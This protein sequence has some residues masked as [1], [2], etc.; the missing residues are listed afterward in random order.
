MPFR[1]RTAAILLSALCSSAALGT[2][3]VETFISAIRPSADVGAVDVDL[4]LLNG[5]PA[6]TAMTLPPRL[7]AEVT[8]DG[9]VVHAWLE[10]SSGSPAT[11]RIP[12]GG[13]SRAQYRL[14]LPASSPSQKHASL[15][16][17]GWAAPPVAF[18]IPSAPR[19]AQ[20]YACSTGLASD[21]GPADAK[22]VA[23]APSDRSAGNAFLANLSAYEPI[24]AVYGPG[25]NTEARIQLSFKY[26]LLGY[27]AQ[28]DKARS[29]PNGLYFAYTQ[30]M[31]WDVGAKSS[32]FRN[33]DYQPELFYLSPPLTLSSGATVS[34]QAGLRHE[35]NGRDG[36]ASRSLNTVYV[37]P[38]AAIPLS[39][40]YRLTLAP[41]LWLYAGDLGDNPDIRRYRGNTGLFA[42]I[43]KDDGLRL[44]TSTRFNFGSCK[45]S[46]A[47]D[48]SYPLSRVLGGGPDFY[49]FGQSFVGYGENLLDYH[50]RTTRLRIGVALV[51]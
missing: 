43:G 13:F 11:V 44:S 24:Y 47:A 39:G 19:I 29:L 1:P 34:A 9:Q 2:P 20:A 4:R 22:A 37:A 48:I 38:M 12:A 27:R 23:P 8:I 14:R 41:R 17:M 15:S 7:E 3:T 42:E 35:S 18:D 31:F 46:V 30:R 45:G 32:P 33:V 5:E 51:R 49:L 25:T 26:Q 6:A 10:R 50:R 28:Q 40:G 16:I 36:T 21:A